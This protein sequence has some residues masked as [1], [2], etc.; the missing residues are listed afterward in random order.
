M[1]TDRATI[2]R[3]R[4]FVIAEAGSNW[5]MGTPSRDLAMARTLIDVAVEAGADAVKFQTYRAETLYAAGAGASGYLSEAG[6]S[7]EIGEIIA[8]LAMP[9]ELVADLAGY[10]KTSGIAFM[11][12][13]FSPADFAAVDPY[14]AV[15]KIASYEI[16]HLRL[17]ELAGRSGKP[18]VLSTGGADLEDIAWALETFT[19]SGGTDLVLLQCTAR[20]PAPP[21]TLNLRALPYLAARFGVTV[22]LSDHS[23]DP[24]LAPTMAVALGA[25]V[26]EKH[27]TLDNRLPGP[28]HGF[29]I[30]PDELAALVRAVRDA[31]DALGVAMKAVHAEEEELRSF[32][33][34]GLQALRDIGLDEILA[35]DV[36]VAILRPGNQSKG[37]HP[38]H[39]PAMAGRRASRAIPA[40]D[41]IGPDDWA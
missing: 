29:A 19:K 32:A 39:L 8:D 10:C 27:F 36:N 25:R 17:L 3:D 13:P 5:R 1:N 11:S 2:G 34:R 26:I 24:V 12:T 37:A 41:G 9:Y 15:H 7:A 6:M 20:Y 35:E 38:R 30:L 21:K 14:V 16:S 40:G 23:R 22:G 28:D 18:L 33:Q 4:V 31:E